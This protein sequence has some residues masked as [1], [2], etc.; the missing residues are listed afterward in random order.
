MLLE[1]FDFPLA[2][3]GVPVWCAGTSILTLSLIL[4][5]L[6]FNK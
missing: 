1:K 5:G 2:R 3:R 4:K 6:P